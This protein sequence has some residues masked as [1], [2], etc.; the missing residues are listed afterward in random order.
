MQSL[1]QF[2]SLFVTFPLVKP[3]SRANSRPPMWYLILSAFLTLT[4]AGASSLMA[5][6]IYWYFEEGDGSGR[7]GGLRKGT[8]EATVAQVGSISMACAAMSVIEL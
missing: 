3:V 7:N 6:G 4:W 5:F 8:G 1:L 2:F